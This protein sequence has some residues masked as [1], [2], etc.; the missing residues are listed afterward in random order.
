MGIPKVIGTLRLCY[1]M[2]MARMFGEYQH[3]IWGMG[4]GT[5]HEYEWRGET[6]LIPAGPLQ[7]EDK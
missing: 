6:W 7:E 4:F 1:C 3:T 5:V 2:F